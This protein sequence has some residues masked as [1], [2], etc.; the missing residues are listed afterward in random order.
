MIR[1]EDFLEQAYWA[2]RLIL[3]KSGMMH[4]NNP[5]MK[6]MTSIEVGIIY[7][8]LLFEPDSWFLGTHAQ[9]REG[10]QDFESEG[11]D[12]SGVADLSCIGRGRWKVEEEEEERQSVD[13]L[14]TITLDPIPG[15]GFHNVVT[16]IARFD[17]WARCQVQPHK[18]A[19]GR[20]AP[21][22]SRPNWREVR[23][24]LPPPP[25][26]LPLPLDPAP[27]PRRSGFCSRSCST[28]GDCDVLNLSHPQLRLSTSS[29]EF[30]IIF[31]MD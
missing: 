18:L 24:A 15:V 4:E 22:R 17:F 25:L 7:A 13:A 19:H 29:P 16:P 8:G 10:K 30:K 28:F 11:E 9:A 6:S 20:R 12:L 2:R 23:L 26:P 14:F 5:G 3:R 1:V 31:D 21:R 27:Q